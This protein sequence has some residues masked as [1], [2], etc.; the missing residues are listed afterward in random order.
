MSKA[1]R[2]VEDIYSDAERRRAT[3]VGEECGADGL[4]DDRGVIVSGRHERSRGC[5]RQRGR[6]V[7]MDGEGGG[8]VLGLA[9]MEE[10]RTE[11]K[12]RSAEGRWL[13]SVRR[14]ETL[15]RAE[16]G[17]GWDGREEKHADQQG[18]WYRMTAALDQTQQE[19]CAS[20]C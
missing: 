16:R 17:M 13:Q 18:Q 20:K 2:V 1:R 6:E 11:S 5:P 14:P 12:S 8:V 10:A 7:G 4:V 15:G 19:T 9:A 3:G